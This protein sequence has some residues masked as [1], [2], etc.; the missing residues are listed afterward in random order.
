MKRAFT[1]IE[2]LTVITVVGILSV[3]ILVALN[4]LKRIYSSRDTIRKNDVAFL[5]RSLDAYLVI[6]GYYPVSLS[7][8]E[9]E[10]ELKTVPKDPKYPQYEYV[11]SVDNA[12][13]PPEYLICAYMESE[14]RAFCK[15]SVGGSSLL[16][17]NDP[18][19]PSPGLISVISSGPNES[20]TPGPIENWITCAS[21]WQ[22]CTF[23]GTKQVRY[24]AND[25]YAYG[26]YT[27]G[28]NCTNSVFGDPAWGYTKYCY[29]D[30]GSSVSYASGY[31]V[32]PVI[33]LASDTNVG[34]ED[35]Y[36]TQV[37]ASFNQVRSW[38]ANQLGGKTFKLAPAI[39]FRSSKTDAELH[40]QLGNGGGIWYQGI[41]EATVANGMHPC[42]SKR[43][44]YFV[45]PMDNVWGGMVG[46]ENLG[47]SFVLPGSQ[48]IPSQMGRLLGG[49]IDPNWPE[50]WAD[51]NRE[52][53]GGVAHEL[54]HGFG[55]ECTIGNIYPGGGCNGLPHSSDPSIMYSWWDYGTRGTFFPEEKAKVLQSPFI[56]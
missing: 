24:G 43:D 52:A 32:V 40:S 1:I 23:S 15:D 22:F 50:W 27:N 8:L 53:Q 10:S 34:D 47:C 17:L 41:R 13:V 9:T 20:P 39:L 48:S 14:D 54:G 18:V 4:P 12:K 11:Y 33:Y 46:S 2:L 55:G 3:A 16:A 19:I 35:S 38:Y 51:E 45:T 29:Y 7:D 42:D 21:E 6:S 28:V 36:K 26:T 49:I 37:S 56:F 30:A 25:S 5:S 44:Y 31:E